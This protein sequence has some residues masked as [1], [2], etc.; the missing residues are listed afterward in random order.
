M[1][2]EIKE[3]KQFLLTALRKDASEVRIKKNKKSGETKFKVRTSRYLYTL[4]VREQ[5][6]VDKLRQSL[7]PNLHVEEI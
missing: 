4:R 6:K 3:I 2:K 7:P 5:S 1:P